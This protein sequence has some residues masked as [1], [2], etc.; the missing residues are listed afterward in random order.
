SAG[1]CIPCGIAQCGNKCVDTGNDRQNCGSCGHA[2]TGT[3]QC[4]SGACAAGVT[5]I[6]VGPTAQGKIGSNGAYPQDL[7]QVRV[8]S[9]LPMQVVTVDIT[10]NNQDAG[11]NSLTLFSGINETPTL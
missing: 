6:A 2:C 3:Q 7:A 10:I 8:D 9:A 11:H 5:M 1:D 4:V